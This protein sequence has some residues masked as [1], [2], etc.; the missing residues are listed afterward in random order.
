MNVRLLLTIAA[1]LVALTLIA[2]ACGDDDGAT[3][4]PTAT[5]IP[6]GTPSAS[7]VAA[8]QQAADSS[9]LLLDDLPPGWTGTPPEDSDDDE[10]LVLGPECE[11]LL[12]DLEDSPGGVAS[13]QSDDFS[14]PND[15]DVSS[16]AAVFATE[17][18]AQDAIDTINEAVDGC[19]DDFEQALLDVF[20]ASLE[21]DPTID[22][23]TLDSIEVA[24]SFVDLSFAELGD[25]TDAFRLDITVEAEGETIRPI[26]DIVLL[27]AGRIAGG[28]F[29]FA[30]E[31]PDIAAETSLAETIVSRMEAAN[32]MLPD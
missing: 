26:G 7:F 30:T 2:A 8:A 1:A 10:Q 9:L 13:A 16:G 5:E 11:G 19:R 27:R 32:G 15:E 22:Q 12:G 3:P 31:A 4:Q 23:E 14:G 6:S 21:E 29:Y 25:T 24:V 17:E 20:R 18:A 28:L